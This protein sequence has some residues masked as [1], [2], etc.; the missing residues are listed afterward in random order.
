MEA[1]VATK[2]IWKNQSDIVGSTRLTRPRP[3]TLP[4]LPI[5]QRDLGRRRVRRNSLK[6][7]MKPPTMSPYIK[8]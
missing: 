3:S 5:E 7:P 8:L 4:C 6:E 2:T 1:A